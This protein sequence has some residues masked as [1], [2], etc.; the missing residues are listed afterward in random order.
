MPIVWVACYSWAVPVE[1]RQAGRAGYLP[2]GL[3]S[4]EPVV[5]YPLGP[6]REIPIR[7]EIYL[8][9][10]SWARCVLNNWECLVQ[11]TLL[12]LVPGSAGIRWVR[13][14][15]RCWTGEGCNVVLSPAEAILLNQLTNFYFILRQKWALQLPF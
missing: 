13:Q 5:T 6:A 9:R 15:C 3:S 8:A 11:Y 14:G 4:E 7:R 1:L 2:C 10:R 12:Y